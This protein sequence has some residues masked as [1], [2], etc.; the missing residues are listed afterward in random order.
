MQAMN[1]LT[2]ILDFVASR[3]YHNVVI[4]SSMT[5]LLVQ[6]FIIPALFLTFSFA[7]GEDGGNKPSNPNSRPK[8][9]TTKPPTTKSPRPSQPNR[10]T[11]TSPSSTKFGVL[12]LV[13]DQPEAEVFIAGVGLPSIDPFFTGAGGTPIFSS[14]LVVGNYT[15]T[16]RKKGFFDE[17]RDI[18]IIG[19]LT[20]DLSI[21]LRPRESILNVNVNV[22]DAEI[23]IEGIG[24]YRGELRRFQIKPGSYIVNVR[25][26]G[27]VSTSM[28]VELLQPGVERTVQFTLREIPVAALVTEAEQKLKGQD[29]DGAIKVIDEVLS[30][31]PSHSSANRIVG[32]AL[33]SKGDGQSINYLTNALRGG[34]RVAI[35]VRLVNNDGGLQLIMAELVISKNDLFIQSSY[36]PELG[37]QFFKPNIE[38]VSVSNDKS[39]LSFVSIGGT[40]ESSMRKVRRT[41]QLYSQHV[42]LTS[43]RKSTLCPSHLPS[44]P[45]PCQTEASLIHR[46]IGAWQ[47]GIR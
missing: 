16:V 23:E 14:R 15:V 12:R 10:Q 46:L 2:R 40:G 20:T 28:L 44:S 11:R 45:V 22:P 47:T 9:K 37:I 39:G 24:K 4:H 1:Q 29:Y 17:Q 43:N 21:S 35:P 8:T 6:L 7:Q 34:E 27:Y 31:N 36:R 26:H 30:I 18:R 13:V 19:S 3:I 25:K 42:V 33:F 38:F 32:S 41:L 5:R